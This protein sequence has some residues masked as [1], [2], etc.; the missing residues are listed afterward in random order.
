MLKV[1]VIYDTKYGNTKLAAEGIMEGI[2]EVEGIETSIGYVKEID[3]GKVADYDVIVLGAPNHM[4]RPSQTMKK[5]VNRLAELDL[6]AK[7]VVVF[8]TYSGRART[9]DR[10][11]KKLEKMAEKKLPNLKLVSPSLS[12]KVNGIPGPLVEGE[13]DKCKDFGRR[14]TNQIKQ[15]Q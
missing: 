10:A 2:R 11:V 7:N 8:G 6:K 3:I 4:G 1:F 9:V 13:L 15:K 12:I 14:I 5:F